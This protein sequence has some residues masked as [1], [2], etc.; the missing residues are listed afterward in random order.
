MKYKNIVEG[1]FI[2]RPNR[3]IAHV[4]INDKI[5]ICHVKNTGRCKELLIKGATVYLEHSDNPNRKTAYSLI[6]VQKGHRLINIDSQAPNKVLHEGLLNKTIVL[7][8]FEEIIE[9]RP[10]RVYQK[11]R[12]DF[13]IEN[14]NKKAFIEVKG[15][16]LEED[17]IVKFPDAPTERGLKHVYELVQALEDGYMAYIV[18]V[19][20]MNDVKYFTPNDSTQKEFG[21]ALQY[22]QNKGVQIL[23]YESD[24]EPDS[25][26]LNGVA[27]KVVR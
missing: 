3:F 23:A 14:N 19:I 27:V 15:V 26:K 11:S 17:G 2:S 24:V 4:K 5:E 22:A 25:L 10:E 20:Q 21:E 7:P 13:Y 9:I 6:A 8:N 1:E 18:F 12:F 16:T